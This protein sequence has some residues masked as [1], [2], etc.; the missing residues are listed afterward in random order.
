MINHRFSY[1]TPEKSFQSQSAGHG[2]RV[3]IDENGNLYDPNAP[4]A[5]EFADREERRTYERVLD[6]ASVPV[7]DNSNVIVY[8]ER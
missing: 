1:S 3:G 5:P 8:V 7:S 6:N 4:G 2:I